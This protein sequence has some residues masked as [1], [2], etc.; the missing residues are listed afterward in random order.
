MNNDK[1]IALV[2]SGGGA[3]GA[4]QAGALRRLD[5]AGYSYDVFS[6]VSVGALNAAM[7]AAGKLGDLTRIWQT[8]AE[9][10]VYKKYSLGKLAWEFAKWK[11]GIGRPPQSFYDTEPLA[12]LISKSIE[13]N[14]VKKLLKIGRVDIQTGRYS[15]ELEVKGPSQF[16][17]LLLASAS[18]PVLFPPARVGTNRYVDGGIRNITPLGDVLVHDPD[19]VVIITT[20]TFSAVRARPGAS[21]IIDYAKATLGILLKEVF[22]N[23]IN[24]FLRINDLVRQATEQGVTLKRSSGEAYRHFEHLIITPDHSLGD[25]LDFDRSALDARLEHGWQMADR[26]LG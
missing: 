5:E 14:E 7:M 1:R 18:I 3:K 26:A 17:G 10:D 8:V 20:E 2:L 25:G 24:Q 21:D 19:Q 13:W 12:Q 4:F 23:D 6:G 9:K 22:Y 15:N 16:H 11:I